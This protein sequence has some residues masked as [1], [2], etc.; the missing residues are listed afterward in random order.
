MIYEQDK[1]MYYVYVITLDKKVIESKKFRVKNPLMNPKKS[2][3][4]V[5]QSYHLPQIRFEQ[6][7]TGYKSNSFVKKY[8][9]KLC[10]RKYQ[11]YNPIQT[12]K[13]ALL[14]EQHLSD[15]LRRKGHG[16]WSN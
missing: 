7:K 8:G 15:K 2:C 10:K 12:R 9:I 5:G 11:K 6:H 13:K 4:Y 16:V 1:N 3:F 14:L